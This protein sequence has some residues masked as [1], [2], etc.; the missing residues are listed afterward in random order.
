[1]RWVVDDQDRVNMALDSMSVQWKQLNNDKYYQGIT[2]GDIP[3]RIITL[4][5]SVVCRECSVQV[6]SQYYVWHPLT[7]H[8]GREKKA[9]LTSKNVW[10]LNDYW[11]SLTL[12]S[13]LTSEQ[14]LMNISMSNQHHGNN[15]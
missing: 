10:L 11:L 8:V 13:T 5:F 4:P 1:M 2:N 12:N 15:L 7:E 9:S 14:W 6:L 3:L